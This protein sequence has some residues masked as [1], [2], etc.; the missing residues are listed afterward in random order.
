[1]NNG[2]IFFNCVT[3]DPG[4]ILVGLNRLLE[5][6]ILL[7]E[8]K[9]NYLKYVLN[10]RSEIE[11]LLLDKER[12]PEKVDKY[13]F[14]LLS[15]FEQ[16]PTEKTKVKDSLLLQIRWFTFILKVEYK[17]GDEENMVSDILF[18]LASKF[19]GLL[20]FPDMN[21]YSGDRKLVFNDKGESDLD[22]FAPMF[23]TDFFVRKFFMTEEDEN[24]KRWARSM[25]RLQEEGIFLEDPEPPMVDYAHLGIRTEEKVMERIV[26]LLETCSHAMIALIRGEEG[27]KE[28][29]A[30]MHEMEEEGQE[31]FKNCVQAE[32]DYLFSKNNKEKD[33]ERFFWQF[34]ECAILMWSL[35]ILK[36]LPHASKHCNLDEMV[37]VLDDYYAG[38]YRIDIEKN[39][40]F[41]EQK[42]RK[43]IMDEADMTLYY[44]LACSEVVE[45]GEKVPQDIDTYILMHRNNAFNWLLGLQ[46]NWDVL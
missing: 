32:K 40:C 37:G 15:Y 17:C 5:K 35:G 30:W 45:R 12:E 39:Q 6:S 34:E 22:M 18:H 23:N 42:G 24:Q 1:M 16:V 7:R 36:E 29:W 21:V 33:H 13:V 14:E 25:G 11:C 20:F 27:I 8:A 38:G 9:K 3:G 46:A 26:A 19:H 43:V 2:C 41:P 28:W 44:L 10:D 4:Q 31:P